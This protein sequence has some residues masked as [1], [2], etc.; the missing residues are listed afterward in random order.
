VEQKDLR[1]ELEAETWKVRLI[2]EEFHRF[3]FDVRDV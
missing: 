1:R 2:E 3:M